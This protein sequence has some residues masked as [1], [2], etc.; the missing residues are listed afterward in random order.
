MDSLSSVGWDL[1]IQ[2]VHQIWSLWY[3][4]SQ[5][6]TRQRNA[7]CINWG[8]LMWLGS[9]KVICNMPFDRAHTTSYSN[10]IETMRLSCTVFESPPTV[11]IRKLESLGYHVALFAWSYVYPFWCNTGVWQTNRQTDGQ[12][13]RR[14][15]DDSTYRDSIAFRG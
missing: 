9:P 5:R 14:T 12:T 13:D 6:C 15:H 7:K 2:P 8:G 4:Q 1:H 10:L 3:H 11:S